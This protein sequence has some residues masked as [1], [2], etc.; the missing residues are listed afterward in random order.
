MPADASGYA[1]PLYAASLSGFGEPRHLPRSGGWLLERAIPDTPYRD[2]MGPYPLF[3]C[4]DWPSLNGDLDEIEDLVSL[5]LVTDPF[6]GYDEPLLNQCFDTVQRF[7]EHFVADLDQPPETLVSKHHRYYARRALEKVRV[8]ECAEPERFLDEWTE[9]YGG[10]ARRHGLGGI[11]AFSRDAFAQQFRVPG[12]VALRA[13][14]DGETV[15]MHLWYESG[16]VA[17]SHLAATSERGYE[18]MASY[19]LHRFA[20]ERFAG[21]VRWLELGSGAGAGKEPGGLDR[22][23]RGWSTGSRAAYLCGRIFDREVYEALS[24]GG[25]TGY[26][27][28]Y[29][30]GELA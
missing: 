11:K 16:E 20:V 2:A 23:K 5:T 12:L 18:L 9:L 24:P 29:R 22:F 4:E 1:H 3:A 30:T 28:A 14:S 27:P 13:L 15:G 17:Y 21:R 6:G 26:F 25:D 10:L 7:K 8:E 19:A